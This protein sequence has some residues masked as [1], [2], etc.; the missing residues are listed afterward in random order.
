METQNI[1]RPKFGVFEDVIFDGEPHIV[2][3]IQFITE[4]CQFIYTIS[5]EEIGGAKNV[6]E[7]HLVSIT[8]DADDWCTLC[9]QPRSTPDEVHM[10][11]DRILADMDAQD[12]KH[13][14]QKI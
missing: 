12:I 8:E 10:I 14:R 9:G 7:E 5:N 11:D 1:L 3:S 2:K 4:T 6:F 13:G